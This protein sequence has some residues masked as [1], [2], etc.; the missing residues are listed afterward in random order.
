VRRVMNPRSLARSIALF[1][2]ALLAKA[3]SPLAKPLADFD[4]LVSQMKAARLVGEPIRIGDTAVVP[5]AAMKFSLGGGQVLAAFGGGM[6]GK[7][8]PLGVVIVE[9]DDVRVELFPEDAVEPGILRQVLQAILDRKVV[10]MG[11]GLNLGTMTGTIQ[12]LAP[13]VSGMMGQTTI[14]GNALNVGSLK[15]LPAAPS[16]PKTSSLSELQKLFDAKKYSEGLAMADAIIARE[17]NNPDAYLGRGRC[18]LMASAGVGDVVNAIADFESAI[19]RR[20]SAEGY[21]YLGEALRAKKAGEKASAAYQKALELRPN[22]PEASEALAAC[23][24]MLN[25]PRAISAGPNGQR[26]R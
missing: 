12:D 24:G 9:G 20:P 22:Y 8:M 17:P 16:S 21:Y 5:F 6:A 11:N 4:S 25:T 18:R 7:A 10:I 2:L 3:Q 23:K 15:A 19:A 1:S 13:L 26:F 14:I